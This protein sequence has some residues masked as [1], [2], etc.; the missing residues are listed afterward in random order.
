MHKIC[1]KRTGEHKLNYQSFFLM[2]LCVTPRKKVEIFLA[3]GDR[4]F[5]IYRVA[6]ANLLGH[7]RENIF[8]PA[9][10]RNATSEQAMTSEI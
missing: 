10:C 2:M 5:A 9:V 7:W 3:F 6:K 8:A 4:L 1:I